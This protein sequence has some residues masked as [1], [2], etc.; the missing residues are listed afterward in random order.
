MSMHTHGS[1]LALLAVPIEALD[2]AAMDEIPAVVP[3]L[4]TATSAKLADAAHRTLRR[5]A[6]TCSPREVV[7]ALLA[8]CGEGG[9]TLRSGARVEVVALLGIA[10][11]RVS[12]RRRAPLLRDVL[13]ALASFVCFGPAAEPAPW[14]VAAAAA[15]AAAAAS[16]GS[17]DGSDA[18]APAGHA[19][20]VALAICHLH[21]ATT[22]DGGDAALDRAFVALLL[23]LLPA[24]F[25]AAAAAAEETDSADRVLER[26]L[27][28]A[29]AA[30][31]DG[32]RLLQLG[33]T[34]AGT[35]EG[36]WIAEHLPRGS[37]ADAARARALSV[38]C[39]AHALLVRSSSLWALPAIVAPSWIVLHCVPLIVSMLAGAAGG[40]GGGGGVDRGG[41]V[42]LRRRRAREAGHAW[43]AAA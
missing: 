14:E 30:G 1:L 7:L 4:S 11:K 12:A 40:G 5:M 23:P 8:S 34:H 22:G 16:D 15:T 9:A 6:S 38:G 21:A 31:L 18:P 33:T 3:F 32:A 25:A 36:S 20:S 37:S 29:V 35:D 10:L 13:D 41:V 42:L 26:V 39:V 43:S 28:C 17:G 19:L 27:R 24:A 2:A